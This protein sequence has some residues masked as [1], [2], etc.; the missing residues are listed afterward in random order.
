MSKFGLEFYDDKTFKNFIFEQDEIIDVEFHDCIFEKSSFVET[1][2]A[3]CKFTDCTFSNC[4]LSM[5]NVGE[6]NFVNTEFENSKMIGIDWT[7]SNLGKQ[8]KFQFYKN[9]DF[10]NCVINYSNFLGLNL[11]KILFHNCIAKEVD[12]SEANLNE[13]NFSGTDLEGSLFKQT[14][15]TDANFV[16]AKNYTIVPGLNKMKGAKFSMPEVLS[17]LYS[18]EIEIVDELAREESD[19]Q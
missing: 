1:K 17:L 5:I 16:G 8:A 2:F 10:N 6:C 11:K 14:D 7:S 3:S 9:I 18:M 4:D 13:A 15:L 12:F 19:Q